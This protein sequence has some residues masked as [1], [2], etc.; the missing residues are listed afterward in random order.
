MTFVF[1][2]H[3]IVCVLL[4]CV[5]LMQSGRGGG[6]TENFAAAE[7]MFGAKT[8]EFMVKAT[9]VLAVVFLATSLGLA[10]FSARQ[11]KSLMDRVMEKAEKNKIVIPLTPATNAEVPAASE[12]P[13]AGTK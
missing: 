12:A 5:I 6:L 4:A 10:H 9:T 3:S 13:A 11:Q 8:N 2:L 7:N 1:I